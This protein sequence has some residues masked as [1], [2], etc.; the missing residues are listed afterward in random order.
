MYVVEGL[1]V[2][3]QKTILLL[4]KPNAYVGIGAFSKLNNNVPQVFP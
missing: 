4:K 2:R 1:G 3:D